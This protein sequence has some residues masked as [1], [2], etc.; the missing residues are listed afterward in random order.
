MRK[1]EFCTGGRLLAVFLGGVEKASCI[2]IFNRPWWKVHD[3][4]FALPP[5]V[6]LAMGY[7]SAKGNGYL[8]SICRYAVVRCRGLSGF[9]YR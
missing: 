9:G 6:Y 8:H 7:R 1:R 2:G 5:V 4:M 3:L